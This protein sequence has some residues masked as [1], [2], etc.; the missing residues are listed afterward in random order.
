MKGTFVKGEYR[1]MRAAVTS[2]THERARRSPEDYLASGP[3]FDATFYVLFFRI[4]T[5]EN[6]IHVEGTLIKVEY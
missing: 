4:R 2:K 1:K 6:E 5:F 3:F